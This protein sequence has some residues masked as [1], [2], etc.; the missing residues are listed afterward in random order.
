MAKICITERTPEKTCRTC[1]HHKFCV[2]YDEYV[3]YA[4]PNNL[5]EVEW[6]AKEKHGNEKGIY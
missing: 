2:D 1:A 6:K 5:G 3:C 4:Q